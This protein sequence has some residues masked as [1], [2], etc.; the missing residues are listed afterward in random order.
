MNQTNPPRPAGARR[1]APILAL[2]TLCSLLLLPAAQAVK[3]VNATTFGHLAIKGHDPLAYFDDGKPAEGDKKHTFEWQGAVWR[4]VTAERRDRFAADPERYA[5]RY[6]GYCAWAVS[7]GS[8]ASI[9]PDAWDIVDGKL[10]LNYSLK[11]RDQWRQDVP[12]N[13]ERADAN[14][15]RLLE[16]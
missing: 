7:Q 3:P 9:D 8:T 6:G 14:W 12:G 15:P 1:R 4:F 2:A 5:P 10:Y 11:V 16:K 13:I